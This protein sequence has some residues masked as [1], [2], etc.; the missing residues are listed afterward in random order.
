M[1]ER[2]HSNECETCG[3]SCF[4]KRDKIYESSLNKKN[5]QHVAFIRE[6][7]K[8]FKFEIA[9]RKKVLLYPH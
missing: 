4:Q 7:K 6:G 8:P 5:H 1:K 3:Y 9:A 2:S